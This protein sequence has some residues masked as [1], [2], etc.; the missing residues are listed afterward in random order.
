MRHVQILT[1]AEYS[2]HLTAASTKN[3]KQSTDSRKPSKTRRTG[4][5]PPASAMLA[6]AYP[7]GE[8]RANSMDVDIKARSHWLMGYGL[9]RATLKLLARR[10]DPFAR[11][12]I[13]SSHPENVYT[14]LSRYAS[15]G[16]C[17]RWS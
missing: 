15:G 9:P 17:L 4:P 6:R 13:D 8:V 14:L 5:D 12:V 1:N 3:P 10:G 11:L 16:V 2:L 7:Y